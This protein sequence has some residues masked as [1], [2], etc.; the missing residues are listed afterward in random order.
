[1]VDNSAVST[2]LSDE[3]PLTFELKQNYPN[4]F[5]PSTNIEF[6]VP[7]SGH[8]V[9]E[10]YDINGRKIQELVNETLSA[11]AHSATF[12]ASNLASGLYIY[13]LRTGSNVLTKKMTLIK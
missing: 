6:A 9:L 3:T 7:V 2:E 5:N 4:P 11:G 13:R 12:N 10:I 1:M 8:V